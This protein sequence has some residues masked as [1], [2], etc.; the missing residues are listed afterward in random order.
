MKKC[1]AVGTI[2]FCALLLSVT[3]S[4]KKQETRPFE[5]SGHGVLFEVGTGWGAT[6][7]GQATHLGSYSLEELGSFVGDGYSDSKGTGTFTA[8]N[9]DELYCN[10]EIICNNVPVDGGIGQTGTM[11]FNGGTG[12]FVGASG[13]VDLV[14][15]TY[16][17]WTYTI[18]GTGTITY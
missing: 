3:A 12:R 10:V 9:G 17:D 11:T 4:A 16:A 7:S 13:S 15:V 5:L 18:S 8:A 2:A 1:T 6:E 14:S